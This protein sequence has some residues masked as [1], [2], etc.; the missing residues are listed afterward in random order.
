[1]L[2]SKDIRD[3]ERGGRAEVRVIEGDAESGSP[4]N[5]ELM[6][7]VLGE[8]TSDLTEGKPDEVVDQEVKANLTLYW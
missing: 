3:R 8:R 6:N 7:S 2:L 5:M 4:Q 1:M